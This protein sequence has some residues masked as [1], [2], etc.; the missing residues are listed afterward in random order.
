MRA[1]PQ[2]GVAIPLLNGKGESAV[3]KYRI[4]GITRFIVTLLFWNTTKEKK[5]GIF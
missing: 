4:M 1:S 5:Y 2:T 3:R